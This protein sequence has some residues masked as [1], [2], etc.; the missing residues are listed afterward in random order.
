MKTLKLISLAV[1]VCT[2]AAMLS[3]GD[4][5]A[6]PAFARRYKLS[7][8]TCHTPFPRLKPFGDEFAANGFM[9]PGQD[10]P[11]DFVSAGDDLLHLN[12]DFPVAVRFDAFA[13][14]FEDGDGDLATDLQSPY[15]LKLLSGGTLAKD[16]GYYFYFYM[17]ERGEVAG[18][19]DAY[20]HFNNLGGKPLDVMVGQFQACDPLMKRELRLTYEDYRIYKTRI[21]LSNNNLAYDRGVIVTYD[22]EKSGTNLVGM[23]LN[24]NGKDAA[25]NGRFDQDKFKN[26]FLRVGQDMGGG[27]EVGYFGYYGDELGFNPDPD[28]NPATDVAGDIFHNRLL[29]HGPDLKAGNGTF[30]LTFQYL[31]RRDTNPDFRSNAVDV[32]TDGIVGE[33]VISPHQDR[34]RHY[35]TLLY[36]KIDSDWD[37]YDYETYTVGFTRLARRNLRLTVEYTYDNVRETSRGAV[38]LVSAF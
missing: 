25:E 38:G 13:T 24:G 7:C 28:G 12:K 2:A 8:T 4:A 5:D 33:L 20:I 32:E 15:G 34:S 11:R 29:Y 3:P 37:A 27:I 36:N 6:I 14:V 35:I 19:E 30:D 23:L 1:L 21:G 26:F 22:V 9:I 10:K 31:R 17:S 16:I 18:V